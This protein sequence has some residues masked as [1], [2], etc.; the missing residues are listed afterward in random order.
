M[1][2]AL[3]GHGKMGKEVEALA[4]ENGHAL[5]LIIDAHNTADLHPENL[6]KADVAI[7]FTRPETVIANLEACLQAGI[8]VVTGTT[9]WYEKTEAVREQFTAAG[10]TLLYA[11]NFSLGVQ[12]FFQVNQLLARLMRKL[13]EYDLSI[14]ET[15]HLQKLD[16]PSGTAITLA[17][18]ITNAHPGKKSWKLAGDE[19]FHDPSVIPVHSFRQEGVTGLHEVEYKSAIDAITIKHEAFSRKGFAA[20]ALM[21]AGWVKDKKGV[22]TMEDFVR[23]RL[24]S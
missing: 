24:L 4:L 16:K 5:T 8:P 17:Q 10:G 15:H 2:I 22:F 1:R 21:A 3:I 14:R 9:G 7:E 20:G 18:D 19:P 12:L 6:R 13:P 23:E 11:S